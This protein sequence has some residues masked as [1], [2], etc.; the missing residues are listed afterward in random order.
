MMKRLYLY[1]FL[2][3]LS[4]DQ[5]L[6]FIYL[7]SLGFSLSEVGIGYAVFQITNLLTDIPFSFLA[8]RFGRK[9]FLMI[10]AVLEGVSVVCLFFLKAGHFPLYILS[11]VLMGMA[12]TLVSNVDRAYVY[13]YVAQIS[14]HR[15]EAVLANY[16]S[17]VNVSL[18]VGG[19]AGGLISTLLSF[20]WLYGI[21]LCIVVLTLGLTFTLPRLQSVPSPQQT[22]N[23]KMARLWSEAKE[24][25]TFWRLLPKMFVIFL[26]GCAGYWTLSSLVGQLAEPYYAHVG[27]NNIV[28]TL[29]FTVANV[30]AILGNKLAKTISQRLHF[31]RWVIITPLLY[32]GVLFLFIASAGTELPNIALMSMAIFALFLGKTLSGINEVMIDGKVMVLAPEAFKSTTMSAMESSMAILLAVLFPMLGKIQNEWG[33][34]AMFTTLAGLFMLLSGLAKVWRN[35]KNGEAFLHQAS[36]H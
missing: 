34:G 21:Q 9:K 17:V 7:G 24:L 15:Y 32:A 20:K 36:R 6:Y 22:V 30:F 28:I 14:R 1:A 5:F 4:L 29:V 19:I 33:Y 11:S 23:D 16:S 27:L 3:E 8:D 10:G 35:Q 13:D 25:L 2:S 26:L 18:I 31:R 12:I